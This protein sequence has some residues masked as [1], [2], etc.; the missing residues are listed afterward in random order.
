MAKERI[1]RPDTAEVKN[2]IAE[3]TRIDAGLLAMEKAEAGAI[4]LTKT[5]PYEK[6]GNFCISGGRTMIIEYSDLPEALAEKRNPDGTLAFSAGSPAIHVFARNFIERLTENGSLKLPWHRADKKI[7]SLNADGI[8][9]KPDAP[10]GVKLESFIFD[11]LPLAEKVL[12]LAGAREE[13][14]APTKNPTG[15]DSVESC[16]QMI[17]ARNA[18]RLAAAGVE[19]PR[20]EDGSADAVI[21]LDPRLVFDDADAVEL[22]KKTGLKAVLNGEQVVL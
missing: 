7:P 21:E 18:R 8:Q 15:V 10:N 2:M 22:V 17:S 12:L 13:M 19:I 9:V 11:A 20:K 1:L 5:G 4:V 3:A 6:L 16:R 14:F